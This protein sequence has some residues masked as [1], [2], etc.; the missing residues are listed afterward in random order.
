MPWIRSLLRLTSEDRSLLLAATLWLGAARLGLWL[1]PLRVIRRLLA[2]A[3]RSTRRPLAVPASPARIAW[4]IAVAGRFVPRA[5]C[6][7]PALAT[8][9]LLVQ[10]RYSP[11]VRIGVVKAWAGR[12][13]AH[14]WVECDGHV[15]VGDL[16]DL[17][18]YASLPSLPGATP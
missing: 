16:R 9:T 6:L 8:E 7:P 18:R 12:L 4:A 11:Q 2:R 14:A 10:D 3:T 5:T 17:A 13:L 15:I 1:L